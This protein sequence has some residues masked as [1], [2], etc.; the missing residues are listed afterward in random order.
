VAAITPTS[1]VE[2]DS[3]PVIRVLIVDDH[4]VVREG[5]R[6]LF[7]MFGDIQVIGDV[8]TGHEALTFLE[9]LPEEELPHV[10]MV[11]MKMPGMDGTATIGHIAARHPS[12]AGL[13]L[14][15]Y[16]DAHSVQSAISAGC[17]GY[18]LKSASPDELVSAVR[19]T[20]S[21]DMPIDPAVTSVLA[22]TMKDDRGSVSMLTPREREIASLLTRGLSNRDIAKEL[23]ISERTARTHVCNI[24]AKLDFTS[25]TQVALWASEAL[26]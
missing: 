17:R 4:R 20:C 25:R 14:T 2:C 5:L 13:V 23:V 9:R 19:R 24:L 26:T 18:V 1:Q 8:A 10:A 3:D 11:D 6:S 22:R 7:E 12:V 21:G 15:S 16:D